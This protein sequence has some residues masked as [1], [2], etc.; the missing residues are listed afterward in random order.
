MLPIWHQCI[1]LASEHHTNISCMMNW[2]I[3]ISV[4]TD[5][6]WKMEGCLGLTH[7]CTKFQK[8]YLMVFLHLNFYL[9]C[10]STFWCNSELIERRFLVTLLTTF[11]ASKPKAI[12]GFK[13]SALRA[14]LTCSGYK[15]ATALKSKICSPIATPIRRLTLRI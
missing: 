13:T 9:F 11:H 7:K 6:S 5:F 12:S 1:L 8:D 15:L 10:N 2:G 14:S 3:E 4:V